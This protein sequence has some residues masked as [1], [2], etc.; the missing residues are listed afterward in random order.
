MLPL[1]AFCTTSSDYTVD[2][3]QRERGGA[4]EEKGGTEGVGGGEVPRRGGGGG[5]GS[6]WL[7]A[8]W[9]LSEL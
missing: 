4:G 7:N 8:A 6:K 9:V 2:V 5:G 3:P 1:N